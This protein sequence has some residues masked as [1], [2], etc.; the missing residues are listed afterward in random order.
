MLACF[1]KNTDVTLLLIPKFLATAVLVYLGSIKSSLCQSVE[2]N[3]LGTPP[4]TQ[5]SA[6]KAAES[7][8]TS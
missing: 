7:R 8:L 1:E 5:F 6:S 4:E 3:Q 2:Y